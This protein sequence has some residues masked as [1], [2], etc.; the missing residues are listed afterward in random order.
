MLKQILWGGTFVVIAAAVVAVAVLGGGRLLDS[1]SGT[2]QACSQSGVQHVAVI[3]NGS[4]EP[5]A[6]TAKHC[7]TLKIV[8]ED[9][10]TRAIAFGDH[11][12]HVPYDGVTERLLTRKQSF[13]VVLDAIGEYHFH[14]HFH[15]EVAATFTVVR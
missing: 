11:D 4:V 3:K 9:D 5:S 7:D 2:S 10:V 14:D 1:R 6:I 13:T 15:D 8:N 12:H